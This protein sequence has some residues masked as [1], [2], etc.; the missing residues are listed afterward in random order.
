MQQFSVFQAT[1]NFAPYI[2]S[3]VQQFRSKGVIIL[4]ATVVGINNKMPVV[5]NHQ[6]ELSNC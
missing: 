3:A 4:Q 6:Q 5:I 1:R 2:N